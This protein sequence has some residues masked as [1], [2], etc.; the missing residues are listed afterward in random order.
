ML[1][2]YLA[3][4]KDSGTGSSEDGD[5]PPHPRLAPET[6]SEWSESRHDSEPDSPECYELSHPAFLPPRTSRLRPSPL[7]SSTKPRIWSLADMA[8][9]ESDGPTQPASSTLYSTAEGRVLPT[10]EG[11]LPPSSLHNSFSKTHEFYRSLYVP[12]QHPPG[13]SNASQESLLERASNSQGQVPSTLSSVIS[14]AA[15]TSSAA[16]PL[17]LTTNSRMSPSSVS[18][19]SSGSETPIKPV[20]LN[21]A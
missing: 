19:L 12:S 15:A 16:L 13:G 2:Y 17:G 20:A 3:D 10:L 4:S 5:R 11:R 18:S 6:S 1:L 9:K 7:S 21:K 8:T 14:K